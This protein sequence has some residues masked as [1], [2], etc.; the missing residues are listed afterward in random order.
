MSI[1]R[2]YIQLHFIVFL[3][4][5]TAILGLLISIPSVELVF[6]RTLLA[7]IGLG[8]LLLFRKRNFRLGYK[9]TLK[10]M[11]T[12]VLISSHWI[13]FFASARVSTASVCLAGMATCSLWT[14]FLEPVMN[15]R[16][17]KLFE[18]GL[19]LLVII[20]LYI[21]FRFEFNYAL[22]LFMALASAFLASLFTVINGQF[23]HRYNP[24]M[25]TF[26]E[27]I[28]ACLG[29]VIF[30]PVHMQVFTNGEL[31]LFP[32]GL[33]WLYI[34]LLAW[35][36]TVYAYSISVELMK[37]LSAFAVNLAVNLEPVYGIILALI[38]FGDKEQMQLGFYLGTGMILLSVLC[39]PV[40]NR[41]FRRKK[42]V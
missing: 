39:Y 34:L 2:D 1:N 11:A 8:L 24:Y 40:L 17:V 30:F 41:L 27:M 37:R 29:T 6:W 36:C 13:L 25:I 16:K 7:A 35:V 4:G 15:N 3:W 32:T 19:G 42:L 22:G 26:Y 18:V 12:G 31:E 5:F 23:I 9:E 21:I 20:G 28:G 33:D 14:S 38:V 10:I